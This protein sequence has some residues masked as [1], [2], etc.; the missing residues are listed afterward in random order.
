LQDI[1]KNNKRLK[2]TDKALLSLRRTFE[3][4]RTCWSERK[5]VWLAIDFE[6]W[7]MDHTLMTEYGWSLVTWEDGE[8][9]TENGHCIVEE[10]KKY[11]NTSYV[12]NNR[13]VC[14]YVGSILHSS[15]AHPSPALSLWRKPDDQIAGSQKAHT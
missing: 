12:I 7:E 3:R 1:T 2:G 15:V 4:V 5:G 9:K 6:A 8:E 10:H 13:E 11:K 14:L